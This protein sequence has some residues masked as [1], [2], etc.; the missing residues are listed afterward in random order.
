MGLCES[1]E[2][3]TNVRGVVAM[4]GPVYGRKAAKKANKKRLNMRFG[5]LR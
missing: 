5:E 2:F 4:F 1:A 3:P